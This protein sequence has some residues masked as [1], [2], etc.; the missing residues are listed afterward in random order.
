MVGKKGWTLNGEQRM[1]NNIQ[2]K[3]N[4]EQFILGSKFWAIDCG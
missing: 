1:V 3:I 4:G 2:K